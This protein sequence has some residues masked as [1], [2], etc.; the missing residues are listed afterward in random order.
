MRICLISMPWHQLD[1]P[2][3]PLGLLRSRVAHCRGSH[4]VSEYYG[5]IHWAEYLDEKSN[6]TITLDDYAYIADW[7]VWHSMGEWVFTGALYDDPDWGESAFTR[8]VSER[9][10][11]PGAARRMRP[12][13]DAFVDLVVDRIL[14]QEPDVVGFSTTFQQSV[15][16]LG[17]AK[18]IKQ[19]RPEVR[20]LF[21]GGNCHGPM[22][23]ALH[24]SFPFVDHVFT[25]E[26][27]IA[28]VE[29][30]DALS[31]G[32][33]TDGI[34]GVVSRAP[35][36]STVSGPPATMV[37]ME[38]VPRPDYTG[39]WEAFTT[40]TL[41]DRVSP[42]L[43]YEAARGCWWGEKHH[44]TFCGLNGTSM[45]F[46]AK[47]AD[48]VWDDIDHLVRTHRLLDIVMVDNI[49][50]PGYFADLLPRVRDVGWDL[51]IRYEVKANLKPGELDILRDSGVTHIQPGIESLNSQA[52]KLM[53][54]G[55]HGTQNVCL[56]REA[57]ERQLTVD[58][59]YL[60]GFPGETAADYTPIVS[61][62]PA[63]VHLQPPSGS[64]RI[65][66]ERFSPHFEQPA[67]GFRERRPS[68]MYEH[69]YDLPGSTLEDLAYQFEAPAQG[70]GGTT[71]D[72]LLAA[73]RAWKRDHHAS[74]L[75]SRPVDGGIAIRDGR[76]GWPRRE[77]VLHDPVQVRAY[78]LL[79]RPRTVLGLLRCLLDEGFEVDAEELSEW[80]AALRSSGLVFEDGGRVVALATSGV[81]L[82]VPEGV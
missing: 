81:P 6:G 79:E 29:L 58:W 71:E 17:A 25:G 2:S 77:Y 3:L 21:G 53:D 72:D 70:I 59:N 50:H 45:K 22:G 62:M 28:F 67:L 14:E 42:V 31:D 27:E 60:Y 41:R 75:T 35:D 66:I 61:Q 36:G 26:G 13:A 65:L 54:K 69:V 40:S 12:F 63:L 8:Y 43:V 4:T 47:P 16:S 48:R 10:L 82:R 49:L 24:R 15:A 33:P 32:G 18:R 64:V 46:R 80:I 19:R 74:T 37:P 76:A 30:I 20:V 39:W 55:V 51:R 52:L 5:N 34:R 9:G 7:G 56:L 38:V 57:Q 1:A 44:C 23:T 78:R 11:D 73:I 68:P